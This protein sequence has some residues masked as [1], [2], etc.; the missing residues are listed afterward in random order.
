MS[1]TLAELQVHVFDQIRKQMPD[2]RGTLSFFADEEDMHRKESKLYHQQGDRMRRD[3]QFT[4]A[5][6]F[7]VVRRTDGID[8]ARTEHSTPWSNGAVLYE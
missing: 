7:A 4:R 6:P 1:L 3:I 2:L 8:C 5:D